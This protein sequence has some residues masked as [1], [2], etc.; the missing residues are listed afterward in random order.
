MFT[1][2]SVLRVHNFLRVLPCAS[3]MADS[4]PQF[5][6]TFC[7][8]LHLSASS[9]SVKSF[10]YGGQYDKSQIFGDKD[11]KRDGVQDWKKSKYP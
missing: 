7:V 11:P 5:V 2:S 9:F 8:L 1:I 3:L 10:V 6:L 4:V